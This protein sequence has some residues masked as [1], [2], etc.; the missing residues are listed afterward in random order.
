[1]N[2]PVGVCITQNLR[3]P[4]ISSAYKLYAYFYIQNIV[5][6]SQFLSLFQK[7]KSPNNK[8]EIYNDKYRHTRDRLFGLIKGM[9]WKIPCNNV[10]FYSDS[11]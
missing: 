3:N 7:K 8:K 1:M 11:I 4:S 6:I 10:Y 9:I 5:V 2:R